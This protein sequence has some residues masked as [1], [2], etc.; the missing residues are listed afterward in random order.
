MEVG[1]TIVLKGFTSVTRDRENALDFVSKTENEGS[2]APSRRPTLL[3]IVDSRSGRCISK[4][5]AR[6]DEMEVLF[7]RDTTFEVLGAWSSLE[8][9][10]RAVQHATGRLSKTKPAAQIDLIYLREVKAV[11]PESVA[12]R[13]KWQVAAAPF[14]NL[15]DLGGM[16][17]IS[18]LL[19]LPFVPN[20]VEEHV[21][22]NRVELPALNGGDSVACT[23]LS[24]LLAPAYVALTMGF[25]VVS[26]DTTS[27]V[28][29]P[30]LA[31]ASL[32]Q[33]ALIVSLKRR[34]HKSVALGLLDVA[35]IASIVFWWYHQRKWA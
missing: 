26:P 16:A 35:G 23:L 19:V 2:T 6:P 15:L 34:G 24:T 14:R 13:S 20:L 25:L 7:P 1:S 21:R 5:S 18:G 31:G 29:P 28:L 30:L 4:L 32:M 22:P 9:D 17:V 33:G 8:D 27:A 12:L 10:A 11:P 3:A